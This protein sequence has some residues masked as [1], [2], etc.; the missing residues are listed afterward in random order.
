VP[1]DFSRL[2]R[3]WRQLAEGVAALAFAIL[4]FAFIVQVVSR[5]VFNAPVSWTLELC[6]ISYVWVVF[7][8]SGVLVP[9]KRHI[10]FDVLY[11]WF[12]PRARR[13]VA[14]FLTACLGLA[15]LAA[16]PGVLAYVHYLRRRSTMLLHLRLDLV[17]ACFAIFLVAV[18][19]G[20]AI[21]LRGLAGPRWRDAL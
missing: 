5:Y 7:W 4:F 8:S 13:W 17:Y 6:S 9:E 1:R 21:R 12:P 3:A 18:I 20:A 10:A 14:I 2:G 16:L 15:Y 19:V 11:H